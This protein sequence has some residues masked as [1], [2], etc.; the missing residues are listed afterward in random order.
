MDTNGRLWLFGGEGYD[1]TANFGWLNDLWV[2]DPA[3][4]EWM[5]VGGSS[6]V[7]K[8]GANYGTLGVAAALNVPGGRFSS[9]TWTDSTG[10]FW[11]F[12]GTGYDATG[13]L[14]ALNDLW[15][16]SPTTKQWTWV[17][18]STQN[19]GCTSNGPITMCAGRPGVYGTIGTASPGETPGGRAG[20]ASWTD[21]SGIFWL[22]GGQGYDA[23]DNESNLNDLWSF[24][25]GSG[26]WTWR[27][28][29]STASKCQLTPIGSLFCAGATGTYG[30][31]NVPSQ[32]NTPGARLGSSA[33]VSSSGDF[34]L[35]GGTGVDGS[36]N[37]GVL[38]DVWHYAVPST[39]ASADFTI[40][41]SP[42]SLTVTD[43]QSG[44]ATITITPV[45]NF[46]SVVSFTCSGLPAG[47]A[48][49]FSPASLTPQGAA[50]TTTLAVTTTSQS[51]SGIRKDAPLSFAGLLT[52]FILWAVRR[53]RSH[54]VTGLIVITISFALGSI[55]G[56]GSSAVNT[57][58]S[59]V[60]INAVSGSLQHTSSLV[61]T[62]K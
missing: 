31:M 36:G 44:T 5:W 15:R 8:N 23:A 25:S 20:A 37:S 53:K 45:G 28:G 52:P 43:G 48:C 47:V 18:G 26:Q 57:T 50:A 46:S 51:A 2:F 4:S 60:T 41:T 32:G 22:F 3:I 7:N 10:N 13:V 1:G 61:V 54:I 38:N 42:S 9:S 34:V 17:S 35:F 11:L 59:T 16:F 27:S 24:T 56:C 29:S 40:A 6:T 49:S 55:A 58:T 39:S 30:S 19:A 21:R 33:W 12:G 62:I 14:T